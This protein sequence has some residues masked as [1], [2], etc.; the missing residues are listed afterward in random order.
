MSLAMEPSMQDIL[1][2]YAKKKNVSVSK[3]VR[4]LVEKYLVTED[5]YIPVILKIPVAL[6]G[7]EHGLKEWM[8]K[9]SDAIVKALTT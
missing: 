4:D 8:N 2:Q 9:K 3:L 6:R 5:Q 1:K 7:N